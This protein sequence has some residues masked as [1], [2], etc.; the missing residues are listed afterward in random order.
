M[1]QKELA[2]AAIYLICSS[3]PEELG[4][5]NATQVARKLGVSLPNLSRA[6]RNRYHIY[7]RDYLLRLKFT[8]FHL[9]KSVN[10]DLPIKKILEI[11][12]FRSQGN[13]NKRFKKYYGMSPS[14]IAKCKGRFREQE[15]GKNK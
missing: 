12:D 4:T 3:T 6:F 14:Q 8:N 11:L 7:L 15:Y 13:F 1:T 2:E 10:K 5:L 9:L